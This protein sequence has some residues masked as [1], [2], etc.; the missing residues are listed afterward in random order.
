MTETDSL[1]T[2]T[3]PVQVPTRMFVEALIRTDHTIDADELHGG[4]P[5]LGMTDQQARPCIKRLVAEGA[6]SRKAE[7]AKHCCGRPAPPSRLWGPTSSSSRTPSGRTRASP[8]WD[9]IWHLVAFAVPEDTRTARDALRT[10]LT[11]LGGAPVEGG[12]YVSANAWEPYVE[13]EALRLVARCWKL[14][15]RLSKVG[16]A[17]EQHVR[18]F[19]LYGEAVRR[20]ADA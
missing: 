18:L 1:H 4:A 6:S 12:L 5:L 8:P 14:L 11:R 2:P 15:D 16:A 7:G 19:R 20:I 3:A 10:A 13:D 9:G 17:E